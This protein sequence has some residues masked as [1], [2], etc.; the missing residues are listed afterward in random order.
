MRSACAILLPWFLLSCAGADEGTSGDDDDDDTPSDTDDRTSPDVEPPA[1]DQPKVSVCG[2]ESSVV[3]GHV[4]LAEGITPNQGDLFVALNHEIYE[5]PFGGGYHI[6]TVISNANLSEP[7]PFVLDMC[8]NGV[9]W[10][11]ENG[12]YTLIAILDQNGNQDSANMLADAGEPAGRLAN[13]QLSCSHDPLC[14]DLELDC[15]GEDCTAFTNAT[16][17]ESISASCP[18]AF[19]LC[20]Y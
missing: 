19:A 18:S 10:T 7:V 2:D 8:E 12:P 11:E 4:R 20:N 15:T 13:L 9:M 5:G 16:C 1:C 3:Q 14:L 17:D 6:S